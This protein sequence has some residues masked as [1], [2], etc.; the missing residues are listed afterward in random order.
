[1]QTPRSTHDHYV[2]MCGNSIY[3][4]PRQLGSL[5]RGSPLCWG[6]GR[7][8]GLNV[9]INNEMLYGLCY[10]CFGRGGCRKGVGLDLVEYFLCLLVACG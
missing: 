6:F 8:E 10:L 3:P 4:F 5:C 7:V 1:M 9:L 2:E